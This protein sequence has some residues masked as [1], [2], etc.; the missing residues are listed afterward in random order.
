VDK[1]LAEAAKWYTKAAEQD[2]VRA[3]VKLGAFYAAGTGV[4]KDLGQACNWY[5]RAAAKGDESARIALRKM[6]KK[7]TAVAIPSARPAPASSAFSAPAAPS[8]PF[9]VLS[10]TPPPTN[11]P[12]PQAVGS[13]FFITDDGFLVTAANLVKEASRIELL[14][15]GGRVPARVVKLDPTDN[16][17]LL[18]AEGKFAPMPVA[19]SRTVLMGASVATTAFPAGKFD[20]FS[21][22]AASGEITGLTGPRDDPRLFKIAGPLPLGGQGG[23]LADS[24]GNVVGVLVCPEANPSAAPGDGRSALKSSFLLAFLESLPEVSGRMTGPR[25]DT[26][27]SKT[28]AESVQDASAL[29]LVY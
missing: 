19:S 1:D 22:Q 4:P 21:P 7:V 13:G 10:T 26:T 14:T 9:P 16:L 11:G 20:A 2:Y 15:R 12:S 17:A 28:V 23:V 24:H 5:Q 8:E 27:D 18:K 25:T 3:L 6:G 29:V